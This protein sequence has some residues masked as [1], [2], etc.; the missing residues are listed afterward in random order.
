[1][2]SSYLSGWYTITFDMIN[3]H[4]NHT[5]W[6]LNPNSGDTGGLLDSTFMN[7]DSNKY[8]LFEESLWQTDSG[9]YIGLDHQ[10]ALG[11][12]GLSLN[13]FYTSGAKSNL[14]G[15]KSGNGTPVV[16]DKTTTTTTKVTTTTTTKVTTSTT[17][18]VTTSSE[19]IGEIVWGDANN[20]G[21]IDMSDV[22][23]IMQSLANP[24]KYGLKGSEKT[25]ITAQGLANGDVDRSS[26]GITAGDALRIQEYL[27]HKID[28]LVPGT[29]K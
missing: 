7:W 4:I 16:V 27:L 6:C 11:S 25:H 14:D 20:D 1:M 22:V 12:N 3:N 24:N 19:P 9:K 13:E 28:T 23:I 21:G 2:I 29:S 26:E 17:S 8:A 10:N 18:K 5:F 15:G